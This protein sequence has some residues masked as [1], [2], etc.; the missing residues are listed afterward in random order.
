MKFSNINT[1]TDYAKMKIKNLKQ[2]LKD[3]KLNFY[4]ENI[5][6]LRRRT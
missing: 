3:L 2:G 4:L 1:N 5:S 6:E